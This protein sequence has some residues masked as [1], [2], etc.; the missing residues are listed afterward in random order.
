MSLAC[1]ITLPTFITLVTLFFWTVTSNIFGDEADNGGWDYHNENSWWDNVDMKP[2]KMDGIKL[3]LNLLL[4]AIA[5]GTLLAPIS[6]A[7]SGQHMKFNEGSLAASMFMFGNLL[8]VSFWYHLYIDG[9]S[10]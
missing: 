6:L 1:L 2:E 5:S 8:F 4:L 7:E 10:L 3:V 9:V